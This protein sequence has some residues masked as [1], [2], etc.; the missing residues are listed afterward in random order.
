M[1]ALFL[2]LLGMTSAAP[3]PPHVAVSCRCRGGMHVIPEAVAEVQRDWKRARLLQPCCD[4]AEAGKPTRRIV[5][6]LLGAFTEV[7]HTGVP[8]SSKLLTGFHVSSRL[9]PNSELEAQLR[10]LS[11]Y[12]EKLTMNLAD[13]GMHIPG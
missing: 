9:L 11:R 8:P 13:V 5:E 6:L 3:L 7:S 2:S 4:L 1:I 10:A 12:S